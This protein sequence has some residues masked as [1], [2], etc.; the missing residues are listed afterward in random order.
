MVEKK[1]LNHILDELRGVDSVIPCNERTTCSKN[2]E[3]RYCIGHNGMHFCL[4]YKFKGDAV[5]SILDGVEL[6][7]VT[8]PNMV[9]VTKLAQRINSVVLS[10]KP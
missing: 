2:V 3:M 7:R 4:D 6:V 10:Y 8:L 5:V 9:A 1:G